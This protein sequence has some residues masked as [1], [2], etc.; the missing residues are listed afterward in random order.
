MHFPVNLDPPE[1]HPSCPLAADLLRMYLD[2]IDTDVVIKTENGELF[3]H[4]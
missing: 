3:A 1:K 2:N 4:K